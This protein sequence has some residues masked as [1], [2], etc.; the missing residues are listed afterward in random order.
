[1]VCFSFIFCSVLR[2]S[3]HEPGCPGWPGFR[4]LGFS[5]PDHGTT[6]IPVGKTLEVG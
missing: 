3:S 2:A 5:N 1:M 4:D 6:E